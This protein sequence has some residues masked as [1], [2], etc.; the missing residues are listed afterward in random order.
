MSYVHLEFRVVS[1]GIHNAVPLQRGQF[2]AKSSQ[3][4]LHSSRVRARYVVLFVGL[5][6]DLYFYTTTVVF[7]AIS[8]STKSRYN[9]TSQHY[10]TTAFVTT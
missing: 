3:Y 4:T 5:N 1:A 2:S 8:Y 7:Y 10:S 9:G 6:S